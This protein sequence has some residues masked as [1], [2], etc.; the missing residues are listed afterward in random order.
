MFKDTDVKIDIDS[1]GWD[2][3]DIF[4]MFG[5][6]PFEDRADELAEIAEKV[7]KFSEDVN[8]G[9]DR[10][11]AKHSTNFYTVLVWKD[12]AARDAAHL[13]FGFPDPDN[14]FQDGRRLLEILKL[15]KEDEDDRA[16]EAAG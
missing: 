2:Q 14:R 12:E 11:T 10:A 7:R 8:A 4:K 16:T 13:A 5:D 15:V 6:S 1:T 3:S 9:H